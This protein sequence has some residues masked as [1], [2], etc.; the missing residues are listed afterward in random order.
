MPLTT[1]A[2]T[3][4]TVTADNVHMPMTT[5]L[6]TY[7]TEVHINVHI[8]LLKTTLFSVCTTHADV[9]MPL[10]TVSFSVCSADT[11]VD[12]Y[13]P[14]DI[15]GG[16]LQ[17]IP[18]ESGKDQQQFPRTDDTRCEGRTNKKWD[19]QEKGKAEKGREGEG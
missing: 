7:P 1:T 12:V 17:N 6:C 19:E 9:H 14:L 10:T 3:V 5:T 2:F 11:A 16:A 15:W 13:G 8:M 4:C 18:L